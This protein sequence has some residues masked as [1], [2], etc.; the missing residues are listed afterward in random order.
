MTTQISLGSLSRTQ[1]R[2][3]EKFEEGFVLRRRHQLDDGKI[4][5]HGRRLYQIHVA[6][7]KFVRN[8][9]DGND[10][11]SAPPGGTLSEIRVIQRH[12]NPVLRHHHSPIISAGMEGGRVRDAMAAIVSHFLDG[13]SHSGRIIPLGIRRG[14]MF[15]FRVV[16]PA[17]AGFFAVV[18]VVGGG[19][20]E[21]GEAAVDAGAVPGRDAAGTT[22]G[23]GT[24]AAT[25]EGGR[26]CSRRE[27]SLKRRCGEGGGGAEGRR[28]GCRCGEDGLFGSQEEEGT[29]QD[30]CECGRGSHRGMAASEW[31]EQL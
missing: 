15:G 7:V 2:V 28:R 6:V 27:A 13:Q 25:T 31:T 29:R 12:P 5:V 20:R 9:I 22:N 19:G 26:E 18:V 14:G 10:P 1:S 17:R 21:G 23:S 11:T 30:G 24:A 3:R 4:H 8:P 16:K